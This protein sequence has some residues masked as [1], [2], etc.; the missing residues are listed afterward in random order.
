MLKRV[1]LVEA[2]TKR[3]TK[4][5]QT[6][7]TQNRRT[8][9]RQTKQTT[10]ITLKRVILVRGTERITKERQTEKRQIIEEQKRE[11]EKKNLWYVEKNQFGR[12][13]GNEHKGKTRKKK[14]QCSGIFVAQYRIEHYVMD[15]LTVD[16]TMG[17][18]GLDGL[19]WVNV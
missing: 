10:L 17:W 9:D 18:C 3:N 19:G 6:E 15:G 12:W 13:N 16:C 11:R 14:S 2:G 5:R 8:K 7:K 1:I 4:E